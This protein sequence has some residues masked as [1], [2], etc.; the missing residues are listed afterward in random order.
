MAVR[1][2]SFEA[3]GNFFSAAGT[4]PMLLEPVFNIGAPTQFVII[5]GGGVVRHAGAML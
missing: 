4:D 1:I 2:H 3:A 5:H